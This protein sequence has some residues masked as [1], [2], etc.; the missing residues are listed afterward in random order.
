[1]KILLL[2][3]ATFT[4]SAET[5]LRVVDGDTVVV[6]APWLPDPL[7]KEIAVRIDGVDTPEKHGRAQ[8]E[9]E[10]LGGERATVFTRFV[11]GNAKKIQVVFHSWDKYGGRLLGDIVLDGVSLHDLLIETNLARDYHGESKQS[12]CNK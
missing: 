1:M 4:A 3:L 8:C 11:I 2:L 7:K 10:A 9:I 5:I 6:T 12:W